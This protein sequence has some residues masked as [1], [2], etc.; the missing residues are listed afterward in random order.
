MPSAE[1]VKNR[2]L[3]LGIGLDERFLAPY[4]WFPPAISFLDYDEESEV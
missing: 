3:H 1:D 4:Y 2:V